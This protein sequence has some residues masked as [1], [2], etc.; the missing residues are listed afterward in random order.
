MEGCAN[1]RDPDVLL[2]ALG[3]QGTGPEGSLGPHGAG[4]NTDDDG[5]HRQVCGPRQGGP[6]STT[7]RQKDVMEEWNPRW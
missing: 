5:R 3:T 1:Q 6:D 7:L 4:I 2:G